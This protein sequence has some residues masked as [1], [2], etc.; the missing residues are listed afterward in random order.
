MLNRVLYIIFAKAIESVQFNGVQNI[1][2]AIFCY[3]ICIIIYPK[4][5]LPYFKQIENFINKNNESIA[6]DYLEK[7]L[8][9]GYNDIN[10]I[11]ENNAVKRLKNTDR[12]LQL[13]TN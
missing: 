12:Y 5:P 4:Y 1:D 8:N 6:L 2:Q 13:I 7:L 11:K 3:D 10:S 9:S